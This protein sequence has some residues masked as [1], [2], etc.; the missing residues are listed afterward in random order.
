MKKIFA[1][2][3][4]LVFLV[5]STSSFATKEDAGNCMINNGNPNNPYFME[6]MAISLAYLEKR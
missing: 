4:G 3:L 5:S 2:T 1:L 6:Y